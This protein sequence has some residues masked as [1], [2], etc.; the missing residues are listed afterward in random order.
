MPQDPH[1]AHEKYA[2]QQQRVARE[3]LEAQLNYTK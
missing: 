2:E 1:L 3:Y